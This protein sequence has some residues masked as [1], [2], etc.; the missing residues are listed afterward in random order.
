MFDENW[1]TVEGFKKTF[2]EPKKAMLMDLT[3]EF[4]EA[5]HRLG[6]DPY[7]LVDGFGVDWIE[8][9]MKYNEGIEEYELCAIFRD[10]IND[11][12]E[13]KKLQFNN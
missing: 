9:L 1:K 10:L 12:T 3:Q 8:L 4:V 11:Y 13:T 6:T 7:E 2:G 5:Y